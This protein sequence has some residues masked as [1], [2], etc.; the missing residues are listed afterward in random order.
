[1]D[2]IQSLIEGER[3]RIVERIRNDYM[4]AL[5]G[6]GSSRRR[7]EGKGEVGALDQLLIQHNLLKRESDTNQQ[8]YDNL[9]QRLKDATVSA[10]LRATNIHVIDP[11]KP[12]KS[13]VQ[14]HGYSFHADPPKPSASLRAAGA[15]CHRA[16]DSFPTHA[17]GW[18]V[19][20]GNWLS[21]PTSTFS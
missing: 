9:L 13:P 6:R 21:A 15:G 3:K 8:L 14:S 7:R 20:S 19:G 11:A 2:E 1:M 12:P 5:G 16:A 4:T 10:G 17:S 18:G